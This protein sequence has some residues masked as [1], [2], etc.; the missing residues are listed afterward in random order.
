MKKRASCFASGYIDLKKG[1]NGMPE[2]EYRNKPSKHDDQSSRE[3]R[4][5]LVNNLDIESFKSRYEEAWNYLE[6]HI[7]KRFASRKPDSSQ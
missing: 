1:T 3:K 2:S 6:S 5:P 4:K 7:Y